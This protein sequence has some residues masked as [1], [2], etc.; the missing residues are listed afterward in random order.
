[1][2]VVGCD[3]PVTGG[4]DHPLLAGTGNCRCSIRSEGRSCPETAGNL[5]N[6]AGW[7]EKTALAQDAISGATPRGAITIAARMDRL[8]QTRFLLRFVTLL[9]LGAFFE[10]YDNGLTTY[11]APGLF[12]AGIMIAATKGF[13]DVHGF[14]SLV[15]AT[16]FGMLSAPCC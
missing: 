10:I 11:I 4:L 14:A 16:F 5:A 12:K 6:V 2:A 13:F 15:G 3:L 9:A 8:P 7:K 1:M